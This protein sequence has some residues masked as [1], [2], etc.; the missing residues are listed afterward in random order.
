M[1]EAV[2]IEPTRAINPSCF[3]DS[4]LDLTGLL[5]YK[6]VGTEGIAPPRTTDLKSIAS[7]SFAF[8]HVPI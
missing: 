1:A 7:A 4:F 6:L 2:G 3:Q 8:V 5:P